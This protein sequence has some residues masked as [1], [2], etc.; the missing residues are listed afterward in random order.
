MATAKRTPA[1]K[2][3]TSD[4]TKLASGWK[5]LYSK[6]VKTSS[7]GEE[8]IHKV[9][10]KRTPSE[11]RSMGPAGKQFSNFITDIDIVPQ[12]Q[13]VP[14]YIYKSGGITKKTSITKSSRKK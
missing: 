11:V 13:L 9:V 10:N 2:S 14:K 8:D 12:S 4:S 7:K 5:N 3:Y 6:N 1:Q